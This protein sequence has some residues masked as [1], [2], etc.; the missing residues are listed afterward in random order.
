MN[1]K[2]ITGS[3]LLYLSIRIPQISINAKT[4]STLFNELMFFRHE[5]SIPGDELC[6]SKFAEDSPENEVG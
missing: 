5:L 4:F 2:N 3:F 6:V 1:H